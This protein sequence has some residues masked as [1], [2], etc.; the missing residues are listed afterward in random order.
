MLSFF[1]I[2]SLFLLTSVKF[3]VGVPATFAA[4]QMSFLEL[5]IFASLSGIFGVACFVFLSDW[6]FKIWDA[7]RMRYFPKKNHTRKR[8]FTKKNRRFVTFVRKYG[9]VGLAILT[10]TLISIPVGTILARKFFTNRWK[11]FVYLSSSVI[12]WA[13]TLSAI[14]HFPSLIQAH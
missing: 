8:V 11:V 1:R 13:V 5:W 6:L 9:L 12:L 7:I 3:V 4:L 14:L 10:P 2:L